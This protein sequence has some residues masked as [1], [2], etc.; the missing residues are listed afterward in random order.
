MAGGDNTTIVP[1][2]GPLAINAIT[3]RTG[4][5]DKLHRAMPCGQFARE[6]GDRFGFILEN[7]DQSHLAI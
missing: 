5:V 3:A 6:L 1:K 2:S 4:F 7:P